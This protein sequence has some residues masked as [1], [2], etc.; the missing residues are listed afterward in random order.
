MVMVD[1]VLLRI[2]VIAVVH[3]AWDE[4]FGVSRRLN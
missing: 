3:I 4:H 1:T 2:V